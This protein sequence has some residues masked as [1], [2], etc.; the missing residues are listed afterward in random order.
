MVPEKMAVFILKNY[1]MRSIKE[2]EF[3][4]FA[5]DSLQCLYFYMQKYLPLK[6]SENGR[7]KPSAI[8]LMCYI[9]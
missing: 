9:M 4:F 1:K 3:Q 2:R 6:I 8:Y 5:N 7:L